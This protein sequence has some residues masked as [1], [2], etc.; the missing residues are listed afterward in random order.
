MI[1]LESRK[2]ADGSHSKDYIVTDYIGDDKN[3]FLLGRVGQKNA[4]F[5][6][7]NP[8]RA[9][10]KISDLTITKIMGF[11]NRNGYDGWFIVNVYPQRATSPKDLHTRPNKELVK[12][13]KNVIANLVKNFSIDS[14]IACWGNTI[15]VRNYLPS[16][17]QDIINNTGLKNLEWRC[18]SKILGGTPKH[19]SR[20]AYC[21]FVPY[22]FK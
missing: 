19:P 14:V 5:I 1:K 10:D 7:I 18:I 11:A 8:S 22:S 3:R 20:H 17:L 12:T 13:N 2:Y 15:E 6:G 16:L 9:S 4:L 21:K